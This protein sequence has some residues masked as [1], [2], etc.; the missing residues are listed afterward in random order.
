MHQTGV[1][2]LTNSGDRLANDNS[3]DE[4]GRQL[5]LAAAQIPLE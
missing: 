3:L 5:L 1:V 2:L 4:I